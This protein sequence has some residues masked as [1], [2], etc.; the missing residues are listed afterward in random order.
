MRGD[1][2][3]FIKKRW[4]DSFELEYLISRRQKENNMNLPTAQLGF[5]LHKIEI[6]GWGQRQHLTMMR[7]HYL[8]YRRNY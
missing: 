8:D 1:A 6:D 7:D 3:K 4:K 5:L 2:L